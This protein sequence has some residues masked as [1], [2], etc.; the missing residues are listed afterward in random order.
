MAV[1]RYGILKDFSPSPAPAHNATAPEESL[2]NH[3][4]IAR[5]EVVSA[6]KKVSKSKFRPG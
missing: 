2:K 4:P 6:E 3:A 1:D 5:V